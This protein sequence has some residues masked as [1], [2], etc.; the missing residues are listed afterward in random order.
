MNSSPGRL[1]ALLWG[2]GAALRY[3]ALIHPAFKS[4]F[5]EM[6]L[7]AQIKTHDESVGRWYQFEDGRFKT[8]S[9]IHSEEIGRAS[10]R[11]RV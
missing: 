6:N 1:P 10:C 5:S 8:R 7:I 3:T 11:E 4:R 2:L 9:G